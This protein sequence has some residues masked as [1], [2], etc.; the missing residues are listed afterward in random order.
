MGFV[1]VL[2]GVVI[3]GLVA[4]IALASYA[5]WSA[6]ADSQRTAREIE[7]H[8]REVRERIRRG[9]RQTDGEAK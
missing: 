4:A 8:H 2:L 6:I 3:L 5:A 7:S 1:E 9:C